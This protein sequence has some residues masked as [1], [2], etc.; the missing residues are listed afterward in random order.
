MA[1]YVLNGK[2]VSKKEFDASS[3][4]RK[5]LHGG[6]EEILE[7]GKAPGGHEPYWGGEGHTTIS[8]GVPSHQA[9]EH[10]EFLQQRGVTGCDVNEDGSVTANSPGAWK[11][12]LAETGKEDHGTAGSKPPSVRGTKFDR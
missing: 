9:K 6:L 3:V 8:G 10:A 2:T 12:Y 5:R 4:R 7:S 1:V 11:K